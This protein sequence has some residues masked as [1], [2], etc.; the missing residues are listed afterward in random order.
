[1]NYL[2]YAVWSLAA[3]ALIPLMAVLNGRLGRT[4]GAPTHAAMVLFGV[5]LLLAGVVSVMTT[6]QIPSLS[7]II[8]ARPVDLAGGLIVGFY[9]L[10]VTVIAP[11]FGVG[12]AILFVMVAQI[13]TS[14]VIDHLG[15]FG[16]VLRPLSVV[17]TV[18]LAVLLIGLA[19]SQLADRWRPQ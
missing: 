19:I 5:A 10:S 4:L 17:R 9:V 3:G 12:N 6:G 2:G 13:L 11:S 14:A 7:A 18:G 8:K 15:L 16:A 1:M